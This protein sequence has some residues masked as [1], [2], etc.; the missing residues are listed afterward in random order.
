MKNFILI[1]V[2]FLSIGCKDETKLVIE[3]KIDNASA[4]KQTIKLFT[5]NEAGEMLAVDSAILSENKTFKLQAI[6][7]EPTF[8]QIVYNNKNYV[9]VAQ[10]GNQIN[11]L[12]DEKLSKIIN[13]D[14]SE[15]AK[16]TLEINNMISNFET[17]NIELSQKY[18]QIL[19]KNIEKKESI[20]EA[21]QNQT[22]LMMIPF[23]KQ[24][25]QFISS[26]N[27]TITAYYAASLLLSM[28]ENNIFESNI[29]AFAKSIK[30]KF[31]N[32][33]IE[34]FVLQMEM[35][36]KIAIGKIAPDIIAETP[37]GKVSKLSD[38]RGKYVLLDFWA[39]WCAPCRQESPFLV[40]AFQKFKNKNFTIFSFSLDDDKDKW[41][42]AINDDGFKWA[43]VSDLKG[44]ESPICVAYN[45]NSIPFSILI[46]P[47]GKI[48]VKNLR[49][50]NLED[51]LNKTIK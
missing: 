33:Q 39:S 37:N 42:K 6:A 43:N 10:N 8:Y 27:Q 40:K 4:G 15:E 11:M 31:K 13:I 20:I 46:D 17:K 26:N 28:D 23:L 29:I 14:G 45:V 24:I 48:L 21:Y 18:T 30:G 51:F 2:I 34:A 7:A 19:E 41:T 49:G 22:K 12:L 35:R 25:N 16:E 1:I 32:K 3:G 50:N 44:F 36:D 47:Q 38:L 5:Q 9:I